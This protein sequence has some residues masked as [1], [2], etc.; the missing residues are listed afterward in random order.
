MYQMNIKKNSIMKNL[1]FFF[2]LFFG[3][4]LITSCTKTID[5]DLN[6]SDP[7]IVIEGNVTDQPGPYLVRL[8][9]SINFSDPNIFPAVT[10]AR[11]IISDNMGN[12]DTLTESSAGMYYTKTLQGVPGRTY[13]L[14]IETNGKQF[15]AVSYMPAFVNLDSITFLKS[16]F[17]SPNGEDEIYV[18]SP[19]FLDPLSEKNFYR[20]IV[21]L[22]DSIDKGIFVDN[23]NLING[24]PYQRPIFSGDS[25]P[26]KDDSLT[27]EMQCIN[28]AVF[29]Y[30][31]SLNASI[32]QG[33]SAAT[34]ANP[35]SNIKGEGALGYF[36]AH[37]SQR[38]KVQ[39]K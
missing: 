7:R 15:E 20:F 28:E 11:V 13:T 4:M 34:P 37:T 16:A 25:F 1:S 3:I 9:Q 6:S 10:G 26:K 24:L 5:L 12:K 35:N 38:K 32:A 29:D 36:S 23:D 30:F 33:P 8:N 19:R 21:T 22:N 17:G 31:Y 18:P 27:L 14:N 2:A 39:V